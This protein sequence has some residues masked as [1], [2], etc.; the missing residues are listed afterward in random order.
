MAVN[1][2]EIKNLNKKYPDFSLRNVSFTVPAG[3]CC[4]FVG[5]NGVGKTSTLKSMLGMVKKDSGDIR[6]LGKDYEDLSIFHTMR[7]FCCW[8]NQQA[9]WIRRHVRN[10]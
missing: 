4:G 1:H 9:V 7:S 5:S 8:M 3:M 10:C 2:I 6:I